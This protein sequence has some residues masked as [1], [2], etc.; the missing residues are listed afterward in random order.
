MEEEPSRENAKSSGGS[1]LDIF[2]KQQRVYCWKRQW[3]MKMVRE[4]ARSQIMDFLS[5][6]QLIGLYFKFMVISVKSL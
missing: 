6:K 5:Y 2:V 4:R 3:L 1:M